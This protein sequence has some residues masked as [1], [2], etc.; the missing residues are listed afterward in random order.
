MKFLESLFRLSSNDNETNSSCPTRVQWCSNDSLGYQLCIYSPTVLPTCILALIIGLTTSNS[1][2]KIPGKFPSRWF[3]TLTFFLY[4]IMMTSAGILHCFIGDE[5]ATADFLTLF[6]AVV[7]VG[8]TSNI[9]I[10]FLFCGLCDIKFFNP[11]ATVTKYL[12]FICYFTI[13]ALWTFGI[14]NEWSWIYHVLYDGVIVVCCGLYLL[15]QLCLKAG[16][17][18]LPIMI[19]GGIYGA[20]GLLATYFS[21]RVCESEG[22]FWSQYIGPEFIWFLFSDIS[23]AFL[24][25]YVRRANEQNSADDQIQKY[26]I[27]FEKSPMKF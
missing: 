6:V 20:L 13:F 12:L 10:S 22:P 9:A 25:L 16:R 15:T 21:D 3:Y 24:Y 26:P 7:D 4:G 17:R 18:S 27:D 11:K 2:A 5:R 19:V 14:L 8:L 1:L 23:V